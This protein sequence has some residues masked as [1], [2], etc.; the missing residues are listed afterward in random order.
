MPYS[1][2]GDF[3]S[4]DY[5]WNSLTLTTTPTPNEYPAAIPEPLTSKIREKA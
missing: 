1:D 5:S 2:S 4:L 3:S